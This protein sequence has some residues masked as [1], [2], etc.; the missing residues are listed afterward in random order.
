MPKITELCEEIKTWLN[1]PTQQAQLSIS[2]SAVRR[3][4]PFSELESSNELEVTVFPGPRTLDRIGRRK[5]ARTF[6]VFVAVQKKIV[7]ETE[8]QQI[9][10][11]DELVDL[12]QEIEELLRDAQFSGVTRL[13]ETETTLPPFLPAELEQSNQFASVV[14]LTY[15]TE[16]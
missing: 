9:A 14:S 11:E 6:Q 10:A 15:Y 7:A 5:H 8:A 4:L 13:D 12:S 3:N 16:L 1:N 2:F